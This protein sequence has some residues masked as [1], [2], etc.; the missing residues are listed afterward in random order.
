M[1]YQ[2]NPQPVAITAIAGFVFFDSFPVGAFAH[3]FAHK[4]VGKS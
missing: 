1:V 2:A 3:K 4:Y